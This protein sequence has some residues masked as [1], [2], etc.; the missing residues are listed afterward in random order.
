MTTRSRNRVDEHD[1]WQDLCS[2]AARLAAERDRPALVVRHAARWLEQRGRVQGEEV[3]V[4]WTVADAEL[5]RHQLRDRLDPDRVLAA[6]PRVRHH[7]ARRPAEIPP[8]RRTRRD[9][10]EGH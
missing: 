9:H 8:Q 1:R 6:A 3:V 7:R 10:P 5:V 2:V 4:T